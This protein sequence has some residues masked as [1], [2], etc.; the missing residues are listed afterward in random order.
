MKHNTNNSKTEI[1]RAIQ[2]ITGGGAAFWS[3][4][5]AFFLFDRLFGVTLWWAKLAA[6]I[7][8]WIVNYFIQRYWV[9]NVS[10]KK[11]HQNF[12]IRGRYAI[13]TLVNFVLDYYLILILKE[14][15]ISPYL[16]QFISAGFFM[17]WNYFW[18]RFWV[19][20]KKMRALQ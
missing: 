11:K 16:G 14:I 20:S 19:F 2:Y 3:G 5:A 1:K 7:T 8:A 9:F 6:N 12:Q 17:I 18:Y 10:K 13:V 15:G 4:Y